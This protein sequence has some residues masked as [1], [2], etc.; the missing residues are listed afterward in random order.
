MFGKIESF[1]FI[2]RN[3]SINLDVFS[4]LTKCSDCG[5]DV[6]VIAVI[7]ERSITANILSC[8]GIDPQTPPT[9][10]AR[11]TNWIW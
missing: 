1:F 3:L 9:V 2:E 11:M 6:K 10:P 4:L 5:G 8:V 7:F